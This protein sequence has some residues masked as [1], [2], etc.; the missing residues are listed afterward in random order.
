MSMA[1]EKLKIGLIAKSETIPAWALEMLKRINQSE[2]SEIRHI[3]YYN[4]K[5]DKP[6]TATEGT[7]TYFRLLLYKFHQTFERIAFK[8]KPD[9]FEHRSIADVFDNELFKDIQTETIQNTDLPKNAIE[10]FKRNE[11]DVI[12][13]I[14]HSELCGILTDQSKFGVW[15]VAPNSK[16]PEQHATLG[17][18]EVLE[19][20]DVSQLCLWQI[21]DKNSKPRC[22]S[23]AFFSTIRNSIRW[24]RNF[25]FWKAA[26][27]IPVKIDQLSRI[28]PST[29]EQVKAI[30]DPLPETKQTLPGNLLMAKGLYRMVVSCLGR[31]IRSCLYKQQ[32]IIL[33]AEEKKFRNEGL[34]G[35]TRIT[36]PKD[37]I[38]A[39]PFI[40]KKDNNCYIFA[41]EMLH[42]DQKGRIILIKINQN[43]NQSP[44]KNILTR[45][46]H[47]SYPYL[48]EDH[49]QLYML[50]ETSRNNSIELYKCTHFPD[51]WTQA[52]TMMQNLEAADASL[53]KYS[54]K[55][56]LFAN[57]RQHPGVSINDDLYLFYSDKLING[58]WTPHPMNPIVSDV[59]CSRP[60]GK[61]FIRDQKIIRPAQDCSKYYGYKIQLREITEL[62]EWNYKEKTIE[63]WMP[64]W[65]KDV[66][67][68]HT[69]NRDQDY[70][71]IDALINR[72]KLR[73]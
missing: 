67:G 71:A 22:I 57:I 16:Y 18:R 40:I 4:P 1:K 54:N 73:R 70:I 27:M 59:R 51:Q 9:A 55:F 12:I 23:R 49:G 47:L 31:K 62:S 6:K 32:W 33:F 26:V 58:N 8:P 60:A 19:Q 13:A 24:N 53:L 20:K 37:R 52:D 68:L 66:I 7:T 50:P 36:P 39:D 5:N 34:K 25:L 72:N 69:Y 2:N 30:D 61:V 29:L 21:K 46:Y 3:I 17:I 35:F 65:E 64:G 15:T 28:G 63:Q 45:N 38:W 11:L 48:F 56:W 44:P 42:K 41:E 14:E 43:G 10:A